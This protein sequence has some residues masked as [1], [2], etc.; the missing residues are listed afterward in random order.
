MTAPLPIPGAVP[1]TD[2]SYPFRVDPVAQQTARSAYADHVRQMVYQLLLTSPGERVNLPQFGCGLRALVFAPMSDAVA[3]TV[4]LR[5][6]QALTQW[7]AG[8]VVPGDV[9]VTTSQ[10]DTL[11][12]P[13]TVVVGVTY[14]LV[15]TQTT[16]NVAVTVL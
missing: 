2:I 10:A 13:G 7:L 16:D 8:V 15:E 12:E 1:R 3:A 5:T 11:L 14:T 9:T 4:K 6:L